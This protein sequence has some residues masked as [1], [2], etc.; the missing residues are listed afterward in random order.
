M[1]I[2]KKHA[3]FVRMDDEIKTM[4]DHI[5]S[6]TGESG[7]DA[8]RSAIRL[9]FAAL[10]SLSPV[11]KAQRATLLDTGRRAVSVYARAYARKH[12]LQLPDI[13]NGR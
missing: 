8:I 12:G 11:A 1:A 5:T 6:E 10:E 9:Y 3:K 4:L 13:G 7:S 2:R